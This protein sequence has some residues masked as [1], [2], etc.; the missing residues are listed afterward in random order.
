MRV[1]VLGSGSRGNAVALLTKDAG[2]LLDAGFP[3]RTLARRASLV[4]LDVRRL[5]G[6]V[7][8]HEHGDHARGVRRIAVTAAC[9]VYGSP[10]TLDRL[11]GRLRG[12]ELVSLPHLASLAIG[13]FTVTACRVP[14]DA[15]EPLALLIA[16]PEDERVG[17]AYDF[18]RS[19][20]VV[21][22]LLRQAQCLI[23]EANHDEGMLG[24]GPYPAGVRYRIGGP[25]GHLSNRAAAELLVDLW[26]PALETVVLAHLSETCNRR[27]L[28]ESVAREALRRVGFQGALL[29]AEQDCPLEPFEVGRV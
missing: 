21:R 26:H 7:L 24:R 11:R 19:T 12:V 25:D 27:E 17:L 28:A 6:V 13:P 29:V 14:H 5:A 20:P 22:Y 4:G 9:P 15:A 16:G 10:G 2:I 8:T 18:G 1:A 23:L 3:P